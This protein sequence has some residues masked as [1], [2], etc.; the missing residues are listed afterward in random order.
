MSTAR[1]VLRKV[2][3]LRRESERVTAIVEKMVLPPR[4]RPDNVMSL[5]LNRQRDAD[6]ID[7]LIEVVK[8]RVDA[9]TAEADALEARVQVT[10]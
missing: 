1:E 10:P 5:E 2:D 6:L 3:E 4:G 9:L 7:A 8:G